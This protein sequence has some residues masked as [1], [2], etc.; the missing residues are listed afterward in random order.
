MPATPGLG[1]TDNLPQNSQPTKNEKEDQNTPSTEEEQ[2]PDRYTNVSDEPNPPSANA[3]DQEKIDYSESHDEGV[4]HHR[5]PAQRFMGRIHYGIQP[6]RYQIWSRSEV[7]EWFEFIKDRELHLEDPQHRR[8][9]RILVGILC[10]VQC[11]PQK[12]DLVVREL[13]FAEKAAPQ[14]TSTQKPSR[15]PFKLPQS[16]PE[17]A[18]TPEGAGQEGC[19]NMAA[20][21]SLGQ[22]TRYAPIAF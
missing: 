18:D 19:S 11:K 14:P 1:T 2:Y 21:F 7:T 13:R 22:G 16:D 9:V 10:W 15:D 6:V 20:H 4:N 3:T 12:R 8:K 5:A 17:N